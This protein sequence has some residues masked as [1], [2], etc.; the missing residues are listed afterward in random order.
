MLNHIFSKSFV[1]LA[2]S[3]RR[4][5]LLL[6][7]AS[8]LISNIAYAHN[9]ITGSV[10]PQVVA[11]GGQVTYTFVS[12]ATGTSADIVGLQITHVLPA[13]FT[14]V[15][16]SC[17]QLNTHSTRTAVVN[18]TAGQ[19]TLVFGNWTQTAAGLG[20][21]AG[22]SSCSYVVQVPAAAPS[23]CTPLTSSITK[24]SGSAH[25]DTNVVNGVGVIV[26]TG[27]SP[28]IGT[29]KTTSTPLQAAGTSATYTIVFNNTG[30]VGSCP[31]TNV[32]VKDSLPTGF[33]FA[34]T[35]AITLSGGATRPTITNPV[36]GAATP[37][38]GSFSLPAG[39][40]VSL[41]F[42][43][44]IATSQA[45]SFYKNNVTVT[46]AAGGAT[47]GPTAAV[48]VTGKPGISK[49]FTPA[50]IATGAT[51]N[52][53]FT[54]SNA[55][56]NIS[57]VSAL[58][59]TDTLPAGVTAVNGTSAV[60]GGTLNITGGNA[61]S[62]TG[63]TLAAGF[64]CN[65]D[66]PVA[67]TTAGVK[68]N[69]TSVLSS[70][71][72]AGFASNTATLTVSNA[73]SISKAFAPTSIVSGGTSAL[74]FT[75]GNTN[76]TPLNSVTF[77]DSLINMKI[78]TTA[79][80]G[81]CALVSNSPALT[82]GATAL[83]LLIPG[84]PAGGCT[85]TVQVTSTT[86]G[87]N[88]NT[89]SG[90]TSTQ[91]PVASAASN[92]ASLTVG[93]TPP[94]APS[95]SKYFT[96]AVV[97]RFGNN[98]SVLS[99]AITN[100]LSIPITGVAFTDTY[101]ANASNAGVTLTNNNATTTRSPS[102]AICPGT[103]TATNGGTSFTLTGGTIPALTTC[104]Y[105]A[106]TRTSATNNSSV[107]I[108]TNSTGA[109][110]YNDGSAKT[111]A[112]A[113][114]TFQVV[115]GNAV[116]IAKAFSPST[117]PA[118]ST[119]TLTITSSSRGNNVTSAAFTDTLPAGVTIATIPAVTTVGCGGAPV[120]TAVAGSSVVSL[121]GGAIASNSSCVITVSVFAPNAGTYTNT[122]PVNAL[123]ALNGG[124]T[125][126]NTVASSATL[127]VV[128]PVLTITKST[129]TPAVTNTTGTIATYT[130]TVSNLSGGY[131]FTGVS[132]NDVLPAGFTFA[133]NTAPVLGGTATR[134]ATIDP[135]VGATSPTWGTFSIPPSSSVAITFVA[136]IASTVNSGTYSNSATVAS[137]G[138]NAT[139]NSF[140][141][142]NNLTDDVTV[143]TPT[144]ILNV[145]KTTSTPSLVNTTSGTVA[146]YTITVNNSGNST[147][148]SVQINDVLPTGFTFASNTLPV[149]AGG[150]TRTA[151]SNPAV[152]A[153]APTWGTFSIPAGG[154][155]V[156]TFNANVAATVGGGIYDNSASIATGSNASQINNYD[157]TLSTN[158]AEDVSISTALLVVSKVSNSPVVNLVAGAGTANYTITVKNNGSAAATGVVVSDALP[159]TAPNV[160]S[161]NATAS[162]TLGGSPVAFTAA[163]T[164]T[165][166]TWDS[167]PTGGFTIAP[168]ASLVISFS[169]SIPTTVA[170]GTYNNSA[171]ATGA[172]ASISNFNGAASALDNVIV[173]HA[174]L[175]VD[176]TTSTPIVT[177]T[178]T[179]TTAAYTITVRNSG[180]GAVTG[181]NVLDSLAAGF[182]LASTTSVTLNG[183]PTTFTAIGTGTSVPQ[184]TSN[185]AGGFTINAGST[186]VISFVATV[187]STVVDGTYD[188]SA[189]TNIGTSFNYDGATQSGENVTVNSATLEVSKIADTPVIANTLTGTTATYSI[190]VSNTGG[191]TA[192]GVSI[193]DVLPT[194]F[195]F[196]SN[197]APVLVGGATR[198]AISDPA[199]G[200]T[201]PAWGTFSIPPL[202]NV[203]ITF[204]ANVASTV[205]NGTYNNSANALSASV[206]TANITNFNGATSTADDVTVTSAILTV[207]K[208]TSTPTVTKGGS[209]NTATYT[210]TIDNTGNGAA[211]GITVS[212]TL[213]AG[214]TYGTTTSIIIG[215]VPVTAFTVGG[216]A[217]VPVWDS[218]PA[219]GFTIEDG[220]SLVL[221]F[222]ANIAGT[223]VN[224]TYQNSAAAAGG[225]K[226]ITNYA[227][228]SSTAEDVLI[229]N[230]TEFTLTKTHVDPFPI[231]VNGMYTLTVQ[232][233]GI[234]ATA[235]SAGAVTVTDTLPAGLTFVSGG[236]ATWTCVSAPPV[237]TCSTAAVFVLA[238]GASSTFTI[239]VAVAG[240]PA[241]VVNTADVTG[242]AATTILPAAPTTD[243]TTI[244][245]A[246]VNVSGFVY[247][248]ANHNLQLDASEAGTGLTLFA[249]LVPAATPAGPATQAVAVNTATGAYTFLTVASG[250]YI[251]V[252]DNNNTLA[253]VTP[254]IPTTWVGTEMP[255]QTRNNVTVAAADLVDLN[256]GLFNG[257]TLT[258]R[259]FVDSGIGAGG[260]PNDGVLNGT[261]TGL[262]AAVVNLT[263]AAGT[264][265]FDS[266]V[267]DA[268]GNYML[269][270]PNAQAAT[271]LRVVETNIG[272][273]LSTGGGV[274]NT[275][276]TYARATDAT[277]FT[278]TAGTN[279]TLVNFADVP[280]NTLLANGQQTALP[281]NVVFYSHTFTAGSGGSIVFSSTSPAG[282]P[283]ALYRDTNC[284]GAI[285]A[286]ELIISAAITVVAGS[287]TCVILKETIP[288]GTELNAQDSATVVA[289]FS[290]TNAAPALAASLTNT[291][292]TTLGSAGLILIKSQNNATP[293]PG[294]NIIY[295]ISYTNSSNAPLSNIVISDATLSYT[296]YISASCVLPLPAAISACSVSTQP[297]VGTTGP[298][299][300]TLTGS[301][302]PAATGQVQFTVKV[303]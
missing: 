145:D 254:T 76:T 41:T 237:V 151:I 270:I 297:T 200:A 153:T 78:A 64:S 106:N 226:A 127:T 289:N 238:A 282:W 178:P 110:S 207:T 68:P 240:P 147:A 225:A 241:S 179:G 247:S 150:A 42:T 185:P 20:I 86:A 209:V 276:G 171:S 9:T 205:V 69:T 83:N 2:S 43:A 128:A 16:G 84:V 227:A 234:G 140:I 283:Q 170:D 281:G 102:A 70:N 157:G 267:S 118:G 138:A 28:I 135:A 208:T 7:A 190:S 286:G 154:S 224:G 229:I 263:N 85:V 38:W 169:A 74:T 54:L 37:T 142:A 120:V 124:T 182:T 57:A 91:T 266:T 245:V 39:S 34:S 264:T 302:Q 274:G 81:S 10:S 77:T 111:A 82:V 14:Y 15:S 52:M 296:T 214:F 258:G 79:I 45:P 249:K 48:A 194:G 75:I 284:N 104:V 248:D 141:G 213:P 173:T 299:K 50:F 257:N 300:W 239:T 272:G 165:A 243:P 72:G 32:Q 11:P 125:L 5:A 242:G 71:L 63:G 168:G 167:A 89:A 149:L 198:T 25:T 119:S 273:Y 280:V 233:I 231:G 49:S 216:T 221:T 90:V 166:P 55:S 6:L 107:G 186:L 292:L 290:Y 59:F 219:G 122:L 189:S 19:N 108:Y 56:P 47:S 53:R 223:V 295:T 201:T 112:A 113:T 66:V 162:V 277:T 93:V 285:D 177:N 88:P 51:S 211:T 218:N 196:A 121:T 202:A 36:A 101:P 159:S 269:W 195:T 163:G 58:A 252:I 44:N 133:S 148:T 174:T 26:S 33:T 279:Y 287:K 80:T 268:I 137:T 30:P 181:L 197:T 105:T 22:A 256:F 228:A 158:A 293:L 212:D 199:I 97:Q 250:A 230:V 235:A 4:L 130:L 146:T 220:Q 298:I 134:T 259:V 123:S 271:S 114:A 217:A 244:G 136:N 8:A 203:T 1:K 99:I 98:V 261:E 100:P 204:V 278:F 215:G 262:A 161:Y 193:D 160:F 172:A 246:G 192:T 132:I 164:A 94:P 35:G 156:I 129:S 13:G 291:D 265:T 222:D 188:N 96:P 301:L 255:T 251:V 109:I 46:S 303:D 139:T 175:T 23:S 183:S 184:W 62:F 18:P 61:L 232:N 187:A 260:V 65:I 126:R 31:A 60:C 176:K 152:G 95:V 103:L 87:T 236:N 73:P 180:T 29:T 24:T 117:I 294:A 144:R 27:G 17:T 21:P 155:V 191:G 275:A 115:T 116:S 3:P 253:D 143:T 67:G 92:T 206:K 40:S 210:I 12:D 288:N 131:T